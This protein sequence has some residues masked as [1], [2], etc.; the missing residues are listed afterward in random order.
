M[1]SRCHHL[2]SLTVCFSLSTIF[3]LTVPGVR[4][5]SAAE[6][7]PNTLTAKEKK[8]GWKLLFDGKTTDG[9]R[10]FR[11]KKISKGWKVVDGALTLVGKGNDIITKDQFGN[12]ELSLEYRISKG[13][14]SGIMFH[15]SEKEQLPWFTGPEVQILDNPHSQETQKSG[16]LYDLYKPTVDAY[17]PDGQ[18]NRIRLIVTPKK[19]EVFLNGKKY[20][21]FVIGSKDW[22]ERVAK[23]KFRDM[24]MFGK[25]SQGHIC[26]QDHGNQV[27]F[28]NIKIRPLSDK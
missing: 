16:Y 20:F 27:A 25:A 24:K 13:G 19:S 23:S 8:E 26:L 7:S 5:L 10:N 3:A 17:K 9:W 21:D 4:R 11:Q 28:R 15:V 2:V 18:W 6:P 12:F 14:N 1:N 22:N